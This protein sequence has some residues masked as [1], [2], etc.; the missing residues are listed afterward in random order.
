MKRLLLLLLI[1]PI[2]SACNV[3]V[4]LNTDTHSARVEFPQSGIE[5]IDTAWKTCEDIQDDPR[6]AQY[7][8]TAK[9]NEGQCIVTLSHLDLSELGT[10]GGL[11]GL[12]GIPRIAD[13]GI[14]IPVLSGNYTQSQSGN[15]KYEITFPGP[16][17][18]SSTANVHDNVATITLSEDEDGTLS[19]R[20]FIFIPTTISEPVAIPPKTQNVAPIEKDSPSQTDQL[21]F[22]GIIV[23]PPAL[24]FITLVAYRRKTI[25]EMKDL[26]DKSP[27][28]FW[29]DVEQ[30][31]YNVP[32]NPEVN[33]GWGFD[34]DATPPIPR[35]QEF[36]EG[37]K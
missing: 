20:D 21:K 8:P 2:L 24:I 23:V 34:P 10:G 22:V 3:I 6:L 17:T 14:T 16:V 15:L 4:S 25:K 5:K 31:V 27:S 35:F 11:N 33:N 29:E 12:P 1:V 7:E 37:Y 32:I 26:E 36:K 19:G 18:T 30:K 28:L 9:E 13:D